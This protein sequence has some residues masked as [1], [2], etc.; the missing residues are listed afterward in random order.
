MTPVMNDFGLGF[1][2]PRPEP[3]APPM[4]VFTN[5]GPTA[6]YR[7]VATGFLEHGAGVV[8]MTN[9]D[10]GFPLIDEIFR[11]LAAEYGWEGFP[12]NRVPRV[13]FSPARRAAIA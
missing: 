1:A 13:I 6:G 12:V 10:G 2:I 3:P 5:S 7:A 11:A 8:I 9:G 4:H